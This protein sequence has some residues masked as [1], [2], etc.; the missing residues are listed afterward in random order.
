M[1]TAYSLRIVV[2]VRKGTPVKLAVF[3]Q[4]A[5]GKA[6]VEAIVDAGQDE[7]VGVFPPPPKEGVPEDPIAEAGKSR[8]VP[9][10][11]PGRYRSRAAIDAF[12]GLAPD[13]CVM[14]YVTDFV[15]EEVLFYPKLGT[16]QYHPSLLPRHRGPSSINWPIIQGETETGLSIFW[17]DKG[18]DTGPILLQIKVPIGPDDTVASLYFNHLFPLG[19]KAIVESLDLVRSGKAPRTPQDEKHATYEGWCKKEDAVIDWKRP[20]AEVYNLIRGCNPQPGAHT[21]LEGQELRIFDS[22]AG[23]A[24]QARPGMVVA[25]GPGGIEVAA[26]RGSVLVKRVQT[27][28]AKKVTATEFASSVGLKAGAQLG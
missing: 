5:F 8:G 11:L 25:I 2:L 7:I 17:P 22:A 6:V 15:P 19:V 13:L 23:G 26:G 20:A 24:G 9:V 4:S 10:L 14:A 28:G 1:A 18:L 12:K 16:I 27:V 21:T 3:G